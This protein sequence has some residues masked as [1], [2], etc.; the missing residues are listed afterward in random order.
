MTTTLAEWRARARAAREADRQVRRLYHLAYR[1]APIGRILTNPDATAD[2]IAYAT[3]R[4]PRASAAAARLLTRPGVAEHPETPYAL[5]FLTTAEHALTAPSTQLLKTANAARAAAAAASTN[6]DDLR[7]VLFGDIEDRCRYLVAAAPGGWTR[8]EHA[9]SEAVLDLAARWGLSLS[10]RPADDYQPSVPAYIAR[11]VARRAGIRARCA[12]GIRCTRTTCLAYGAVWTHDGTGQ[13]PFLCSGCIPAANA[14]RAAR[15]F[16]PTLRAVPG[17]VPAGARYSVTFYNG[18][19]SGRRTVS[20]TTP[21][22]AQFT[23]ETVRP[24]N[25]TGYTIHVTS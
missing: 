1:V 11:E 14:E 22:E 13:G 17:G 12:A 3:T 9:A 20:C 15:G 6:N 18:S 16:A 8:H 25:N 4:I 7:C 21:Q 10:P 19:G 23:A 24:F 2:D 5:S